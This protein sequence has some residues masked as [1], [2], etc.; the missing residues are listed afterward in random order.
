MKER[1]QGGA[2]LVTDI[3]AMPLMRRRIG[4]CSIC[5]GDV[6]GYRGAFQSVNLPPPDT[7][8][9]CGAMRRIDVIEMVPVTRCQQA[10]AWAGTYRDDRG[11]WVSG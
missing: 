8:T 2:W 3:G 9:Q 1:N 11:S 6:M 7:C 4:T 10:R 5:G